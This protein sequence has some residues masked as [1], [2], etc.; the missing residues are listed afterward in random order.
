M[1]QVQPATDAITQVHEALT[2]LS[3]KREAINRIVD[4]LIRTLQLGNKLLTCGNGGSAAEAMHL[5]EELVG[6]FSRRRRPLASIC[7]SSDPTILSCIANDFGFDEVFA[8]QIEGLASPGDG[9]MVL[10]TSGKS[11]NILRAL[12]SARGNGIKTIGLL[13]PRES[14]AERLCDL[15]L[16]LD[17]VG[18]ARVQEMHLV[19]IHMM[20]EKIDATFS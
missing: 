5:T 9:L 15:A 2:V 8:R 17:D 18:P 11:P 3:S 12:E 13:G 1:D 20:L 16:T 4:L 19:V 14:P 7:L 6:R 10:S